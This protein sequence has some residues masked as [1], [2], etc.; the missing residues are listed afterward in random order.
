MR[1][2]RGQNEGLSWYKISAMSTHFAIARAAAI[3]FFVLA[4]SCAAQNPTGE[5]GEVLISKFFDPVYP[6]LARQTGI[7]GDVELSLGIRN[8]GSIESM[9]VVHGHPVLQTAALESAKRSEFDCRGCGSATVSYH[10]VYSFRLVGQGCCADTAVT[11][12]KELSESVPRV[13]RSG[14][15]VTVVDR[16]TCIC[17]P[18]ISTQKVRSWKCVY[19]WRC[20]VRFPLRP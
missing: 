9:A 15:H 5:Q 16:A 6:T 3:T 7:T 2:R 12:N 18:A 11:S 19:L 1:D 10:L 20:A 4:S 17:D 8:D 14:N 13:V